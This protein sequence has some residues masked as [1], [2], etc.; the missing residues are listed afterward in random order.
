MFIVKIE[1]GNSIIGLWILRL[2]FNRN[3]L[4]I[5]V[6]FND[7]KPL[8]IIDVIAKYCSSLRIRSGFSQMF[9]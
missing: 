3:C 6:K 4:A 1:S 2:F 5:L 9:S 7:T 8:R